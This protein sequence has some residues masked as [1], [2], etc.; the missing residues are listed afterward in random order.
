MRLRGQGCDQK[1]KSNLKFVRFICYD[2]V[3]MLMDHVGIVY[4][5]IY[6]NHDTHYHPETANRLT[7]TIKKLKTLN[8]YGEHQNHQYH[9][10]SPRKASISDIKWIHHPNFINL[11]QTTADLARSSPEVL[12]LD[13]KNMRYG[14]TIASAGTFNAALNAVGGNFQ[15]IDSIMQSE[16]KRCFVLCRPPG[17]HSNSS[18]ARGFCVFNNVLLAAEYL[19]RK[20]GLKKIAIID[21]DAHAGNGTEEML[22]SHPLSGEVL[23]FSM[24]QH[25]L[26]LYPGTCFANEIG[27]GAQ[28]GKIINLTLLPYSGHQCVK[29]LFEEIISPITN[30]F[31]PEFILVSAGYDGHHADP[32][33]ALG[34]LEQTYTYI[35]QQLVKL[36]SSSAQ[37]RIQCT[38]EG[39]YNLEALSRS[40]SNTIMTFAGET[41]P[42]EEDLGEDEEKHEKYL[43]E[44]LFPTLR[45]HL[46]PYWKF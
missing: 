30:Q 8:L 29:K 43:Q 35:G 10:I 41:S 7:A 33:T 14:E 38:L 5:E 32:L 12:Y 37:G 18:H 26:T 39:G 6:L 17:H 23:F 13:S 24:H 36:A 25:P 40:I 2:S 15:G 21:F 45:T 44:T 9:T 1:K 22:N 27:T 42:Y 31:Q 16:I 46:S 3:Y 20:Y 19:F 34:F 4:D 11:V 28:K